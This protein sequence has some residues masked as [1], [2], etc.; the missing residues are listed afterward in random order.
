MPSTKS[1]TWCCKFSSSEL[2]AP[3]LPPQL[4]FNFG[5]GPCAAPGQGCTIRQGV[6][7][8]VGVS[9]RP[10]CLLLQAQ[11]VFLSP[12]SQPFQGPARHRHNSIPWLLPWLLILVCLLW[13]QQNTRDQVLCLF[14]EVYASLSSRVPR[15]HWL[16]VRASRLTALTEGGHAREITWG[17]RESKR[18]SGESRIL[19]LCYNP[20]WG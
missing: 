1:N 13:L 5:W 15:Q 19:F 2:Q 6:E 18:T 12:P 7:R 16:L 10:C 14:R 11:L 17:D 3:Q 20:L 8:Q 9:S 4:L